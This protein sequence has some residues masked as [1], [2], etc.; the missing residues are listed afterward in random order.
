MDEDDPGISPALGNPP[1]EDETVTPQ[2]MTKRYKDNNELPYR[3][4][5]IFSFNTSQGHYKFGNYI[6]I[7]TKPMALE[8]RRKKEAPIYTH[9]RELTQGY[10]NSSSQWL[11]FFSSHSNFS[12]GGFVACTTP[13]THTSSFHTISSRSGW[14]RTTSIWTSILTNDLEHHQFLS[15]LLSSPHPSLPPKFQTHCR[16]H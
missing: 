6:T 14:H 5:Y 10:K 16:S 2:S 9:S 12:I 4:R 3:W 7:K 1:G 11:I 13:V 8:G 15:P